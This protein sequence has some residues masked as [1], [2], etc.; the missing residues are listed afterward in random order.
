MPF[1]ATWMNLETVILNEINLTEK[2][3]YH[4]VAYMWN[5]KRKR[6]NW[7][8]LQNRN[9]VTDVQNKCMVTK[10]GKSSKKHT[11]GHWTDRHTAL[12][13]KKESDVVQSCL[14]LCNPMD[15]N[16]LDS[17]VHGIL[18]ARIVEWAATFFSRGSSQHRD[19][20]WVPT[21]QADSLPSKPP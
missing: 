7:T 14:T 8:Y 5:L 9:R 1:A 2:N 12:Y 19:R 18:Q 13:V 6:Y 16:L 17:F 3:K 4:D 10:G 11:L 21:L 20:S 15:C